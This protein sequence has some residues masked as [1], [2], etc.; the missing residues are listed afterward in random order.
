MG[1]V[2]AA[3]Q[4][5]LAAAKVLGT[6]AVLLAVAVHSSEVQTL[7][8]G[9]ELAY[10][11]PEMKVEEKE[12]KKVMVNREAFYRGDVD[13]DESGLDN[14]DDSNL[15]EIWNAATPQAT[16]DAW[17]K[18]V[19]DGPE[20]GE[21]QG[22]EAS[23]KT[24]TYGSGK[25]GSNAVPALPE[26]SKTDEK[27]M[28]AIMDKL[29][30]M[31]NEMSVL[32]GA[33]WE[34]ILEQHRD[35]VVQVMVV[36]KKFLWKAA[37]RS[38]MSEEISGS[39]WFIKNDEFETSTGGDLLVVTNAHVAKN[40]AEINP[41][42]PS[43]GQEP[44]PAEVVGLCSQRDIAILKVTN[45]EKLLE[46]Y[47]TTTGK[48]DIIRMKL[49][50]SDEM[51]RGA[52]VM[53]V[54][55][56]LGMKSVKASMG[57]VSGY[58]QFKSALYLQI[59]APINPGN[60]GGPLFNEKGQVVGINSAK[61]A[62]ASG[63]SF[64]ISSVQLKVMLDVLYQRRQFIVP[65][66]GYGFS[67]GTKLIQQYLKV[68]GD[69]DKSGGIYMTKVHPNG[70]FKE[71]GVKKGGLLLTVDGASIDRF[72]QTWM[73]TMK[74]NINILGL[75]AR[76]K[77][78]TQLV[79]GV[80]RKSESKMLSLNAK[81]DSTPS[82]KVPFIYEPTIDKPKYQTFAGIVFMELSVNLVTV[83][84]QTNVAELIQ[85][86]KPENR[87]KS[88]VVVAGVLPGSIASLDGSVKPGLVVKKVNGQKIS[89]MSDICRVLAAKANKWYTVSTSQTFTALKA[90]DVN[91][92]EKQSLKQHSN[93][94]QFCSKPKR[95][96]AGTS[97]V[98]KT[99]K[100]KKKAPKKK[101]P[102]KKAPKKKA[103]KKAKKAAPKKAKKA[104]PKTKKANKQY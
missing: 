91:L 79:L 61:I 67:V 85:Y 77:I 18:T 52:R 90:K 98:K 76:K 39:G 58:Q 94:G 81:Y 29:V 78:G 57:I 50:D 2:M 103:P 45:P 102:K 12:G 60:S 43:L 8:E 72:G 86:M 49:G 68:K 41:L 36:K 4:A 7:D 28:P 11:T 63:M 96:T 101:A 6:L 31:R 92:F 93:V 66:L 37:Y 35:G 80:W 65:Y 17:P 27:Y 104:A 100:A 22:V 95:K 19:D 23:A 97:K 34:D 87:M 99:G 25:S 5:P 13:S 33:N 74:D 48:S 38:A 89:S 32:K 64:A 88:A 46:L 75:L 16:P 1:R 82:F 24:K 26:I 62:S 9:R 14:G 71:A 15:A 83:M 20:L 59:T 42:V 44:I 3:F 70:L 40:A 54:G 56:P 51:K 84:L 10:S 53:A 73:P 55:Y 30:N 21:S 69:K 47:K